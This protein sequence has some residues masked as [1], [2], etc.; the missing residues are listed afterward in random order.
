MIF[1]AANF[2]NFRES[3]RLKKIYAYLL[4]DLDEKN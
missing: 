1:Y 4:C 3:Y 2:T